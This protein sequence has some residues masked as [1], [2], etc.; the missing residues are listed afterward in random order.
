[1]SVIIIMSMVL[2]N[3]IVMN[4]IPCPWCGKVSRCYKHNTTSMA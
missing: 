1:M 4:V 3:V 2:L